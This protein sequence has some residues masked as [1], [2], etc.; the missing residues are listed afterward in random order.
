MF[1]RPMTDSPTEP[2]DDEEAFVR[3]LRSLI[4]RAHRDGIEVEQHWAVHTDES[5]PDW[6][7]EVVRVKPKAMTD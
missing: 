5:S 7:V 2:R 6:E 3:E 1:E 4:E